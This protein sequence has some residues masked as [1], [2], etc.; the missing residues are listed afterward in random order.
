MTDSGA[1]F[2]G[3]LPWGVESEIIYAEQ[4]VLGDVDLHNAADFLAVDV[5]RDE[6]SMTFLFERTEDQRRFAIRFSKIRSVEIHEAKDY[7]PADEK[8]FYA[9]DSLGDG[10]FE[11]EAAKASGKL[12]A[13]EVAFEEV[14]D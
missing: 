12:Q 2:H 9:F 1:T 7:C 13:A 10:L 5:S 11:F 4:T 3:M 6:D 14:T 8:L